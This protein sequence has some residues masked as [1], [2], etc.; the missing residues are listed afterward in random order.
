MVGGGRHFQKWSVNVPSLADD[1]W[2]EGVQQYIPL[3]ISARDRYIQLKFLHR[4]Y[5]TA[6]RLA[7]IYP[8]QSDSVSEMQY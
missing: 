5:Y 6:H 1:D 4:A 2:E 7:R 8:A 3:M